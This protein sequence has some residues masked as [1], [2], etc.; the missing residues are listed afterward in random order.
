VIDLQDK[1]K[2]TG[3]LN[4]SEFQQRTRPEGPAQLER[5][6]DPARMVVAPG[7]YRTAARLWQE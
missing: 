7:D 2:K 4:G 1:I 3:T 5:D 6:L